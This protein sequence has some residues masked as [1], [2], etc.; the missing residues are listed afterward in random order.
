MNYYS[1]HGFASLS[2]GP[3]LSP[4][5]PETAPKTALVTG[6]AGFLGSHLCDHLLRD[7]ARVLCLDNFATGSLAN[8]AHLIDDPRFVIVRQDVC[9]PLLAE[10]DEIYNLACP[11]SPP[12]Y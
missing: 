4:R 8:V 9:E 3:A 7:G 6:G 10:V 11:A 5:S 12:H 1:R 2:A